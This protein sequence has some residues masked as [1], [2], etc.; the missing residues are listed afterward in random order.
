MWH[1]NSK[2]T[3]PLGKSQWGWHSRGLPLGTCSW[4]MQNLPHAR[5]GSHP[6]GWGTLA[7]GGPRG[8]HTPP[9]M[10]RDPWAHRTHWADWC[11]YYL[12]SSV[13]HII[14]RLPPL[15]KGKEILVRDWSQPKPHYWVDLVL[16]GEKQKGSWLV[17]GILVYSPL[18]GWVLQWDSS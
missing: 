18:Q 9:G 15:P 10:S 2:D 1:K 6:P 14:T 5:G 11:F 8:C 17:E 13:S 4:G 16:C 12:C 7:A 3:W